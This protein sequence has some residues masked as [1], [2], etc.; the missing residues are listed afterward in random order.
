MNNGLSRELPETTDV[1]V[2]GGG[3]AGL[4]AA[5]DL[6]D[7]G[8]KVHVLEARSRLGGRTDYVTFPGTR[9]KVEMGGTWVASRFHP[10]VMEE[11]DRYGLSLVHERDSSFRWALD[12]AP[13]TEGFPIVGDEIYDLERAFAEIVFAAR[14]LDPT[15]RRDVQGDL[16]DLDVTVHDWVSSLELSH[17][18]EQ[19][20]FMM[21]SLGMGAHETEWSALDAFS[22]LSGMQ[23]SPYGWLAA[24]GE[25]FAGGTSSL[26]DSLASQEGIEIHLKTPVRAIHTVGNA[27]DVVTDHGTVRA[28]HVV[29]AT[30]V[31][32]WHDLEFTPPLEGAKSALATEGHRGRMVKLW[33]LVDQAPDIFA[34]G[35]GTDFLC[36]NTQ[37]R[38]PEGVILI[39]FA[40]PPSSFRGLDRSSVEA[41]LKEV[42][43]DSV[44][45]DHIGHDWAEDPWSQGTWMGYPTGYL[46]QSA[47]E[48]S[49]PVGRVK[50]AGADL[51]TTWI[52]WMEGALESGRD[53]ARSIFEG[54]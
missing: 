8:K 35:R 15:I 37:Y 20:I 26:V 40:S 41:A 24:A 25:K 4:R 33:L 31:N 54:R 3:I 23:C 52:G 14:R 32:T 16:S 49:A 27:V 5:R 12:G 44:L 50:F 38:V 46:S 47:T 30:P 22:L 17:N 34:L 21:V 29:V 19:F 42:L 48:I 51:A 36:L 45:I 18:V 10:L 13:F 2:I 39:A 6:A 43:P 7:A 11:V 9:Q 53:A 1:V 28:Q